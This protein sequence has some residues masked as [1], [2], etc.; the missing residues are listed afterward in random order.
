MTWRLKSYSLLRPGCPSLQLCRA[1][2][3]VPG[4]H[5]LFYIHGP[6][7]I[8]HRKWLFY[9]QSNAY[10]FFFFKAFVVHFGV[11]LPLHCS[12][13]LLAG[14]LPSVALL[15]LHNLI[16]GLPTPSAA[17]IQ[18][19]LTTGLEYSWRQSCWSD[20]SDMAYWG[21][22]WP[23]AT[24]YVVDFSEFY[25]KLIWHSLL[26]TAIFL[27]YL[28]LHPPSFA[29]RKQR[30]SPVLL[31]FCFKHCCQVRFSLH[32]STLTQIVLFVLCAFSSCNFSIW[33]DNATLGHVT[34]PVH[35]FCTLSTY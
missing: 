26:L 22:E 14:Q 23:A 13:H 11:L 3:S 32:L 1:R 19:L 5:S 12:F 16:P 30:V 31:S 18:H 9:Q 2:Y 10:C 21:R 6:L 33:V 27:C 34:K 24:N 17:N 4:N 25:N 35:T 29:I 7:Y 15:N 20:L 8:H 28:R